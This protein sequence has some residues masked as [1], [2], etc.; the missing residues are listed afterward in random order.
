MLKQK[1]LLLVYT[2]QSPR[3]PGLYPVRTI[4]A[5][6]PLDPVSSF[7]LCSRRLQTRYQ[8]YAFKSVHSR[9]KE[10]RRDLLVPI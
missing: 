9:R 2:T 8:V 5:R 4:L 3:C 10:H 7:L 1:E 6:P